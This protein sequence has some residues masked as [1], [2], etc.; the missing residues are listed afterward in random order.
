MLTVV[1]IKAPNGMVITIRADIISESLRALYTEGDNLIT[2]LNNLPEF[3]MPN[4]KQTYDEFVSYRNNLLLK[5]H[6]YHTVIDFLEQHKC[7]I[8][9]DRY[10]STEGYGITFTA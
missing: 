5:V 8:L 1:S 2:T 4:D 9:I 7:E 6:I 10:K 3:Y